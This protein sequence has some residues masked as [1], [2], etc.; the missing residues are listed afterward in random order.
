MAKF[1]T[2][3]GDD[4]YTGLLGEERVPK[5]H[6]RPEAVG[7]IDEASAAIGLARAT[8]QEERTAAL[9]LEIQRDLYLIMAEIAA[10]P[11]NAAKFRKIGAQRVLWLES[12]IDALSSEVDLPGEFIVPGDSP[13]GATLAVAR[14]F[15]RRAERQLAK[16]IHD[17]MIESDEEQCTQLHPSKTIFDVSARGGA[18]R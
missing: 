1:Y 6:P 13:S 7:A 10:T 17:N 14:S 11:E 16:L 15:V 5:Y 4:G 8:C 9:L 3:K 2:R 12:Q 18:C